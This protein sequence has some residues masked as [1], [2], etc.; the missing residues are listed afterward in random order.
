VLLEA[1]AQ[2][3][4]VVSTAEMGT[5]DVLREGAGVWIAEENIEDF[6]AK[7]IA[8]LRDDQARLQLGEAGR[9]YAYGWSASKQAERMLTFYQSVIESHRPIGIEHPVELVFRHA[10]HEGAVLP[11]DGDCPGRA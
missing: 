11:V 7:V 8:M 6:S 2:G 9:D 3:V 4:P 10:L 1:M 5:K